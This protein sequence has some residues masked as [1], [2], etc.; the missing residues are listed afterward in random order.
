MKKISIILLIVAIVIISLVVYMQ[1][2][3]ENVWESKETATADFEIIFNESKNSGKKK[4]IS[5]NISVKDSYNIYSYDGDVKIKINGIEYALKEALLQNK[6]SADDILHKAQED[7]RKKLIKSY[8]LDD[9][10]TIWYEYE[11]YLII[12]F[13]KLNGNKDLYIGSLNMND[14]VGE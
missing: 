8:A 14:S 5:K 2:N 4:I 7:V 1:I 10:G 9:G 11:T 12:K 3:K 13:N 6:I